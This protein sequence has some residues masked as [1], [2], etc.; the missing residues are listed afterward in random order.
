MCLIGLSS[1][2]ILVH[3]ESDYVILDRP[4]ACALRR[5]R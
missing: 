5:E 1:T 2:V 4:D 3:G